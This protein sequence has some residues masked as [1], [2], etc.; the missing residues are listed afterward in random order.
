MADAITR[1]EEFVWLDPLRQAGKIICFHLS[2]AD[3]L[4]SRIAQGGEKDGEEEES[5]KPMLG[6]ARRPAARK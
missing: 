3:G 1:P 5:R 6:H 2:R 4:A